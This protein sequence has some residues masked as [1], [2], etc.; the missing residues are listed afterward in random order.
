LA[1][2]FSPDGA[3]LASG[4]SD[5]MIRLWDA[6]TA[7]L[8]AT[9]GPHAGKVEALAFSPDGSRV[10]AATEVGEGSPGEV[11]LWEVA[12]GRLQADLKGYEDSVNCVAFSADGSLLATGDREGQIRLW[13]AAAGR[14]KSAIPKAHESAV[15]SLAFTK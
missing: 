2:A 12:T 7:G 6:R 14:A 10:A 9:L 8:R 4:G 13:D 1:V 15:R 11:K 3:L 5:R